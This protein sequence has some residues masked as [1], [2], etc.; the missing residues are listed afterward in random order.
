MTISAVDDAV[1]ENDPHAASIDFGFSSAAD[2]G[3]AALTNVPAIG[4][5]ILENDCGAWGYAALDRNED[6]VI[7]LADFAEFAQLWLACTMPNDPACD[8]LRQP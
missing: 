2:S 3:Y 6:C 1:V 5:D 4:V 7:D 8:D